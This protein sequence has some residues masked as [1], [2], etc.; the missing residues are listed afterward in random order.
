MIQARQLG[1]VFHPP[2]SLGDLLRG[3][4][5]G[6]AVTALCDVS[7]D[8]AAGEVVCL[9]GENGAGKTTLLRLLAGLLVPSTGRALV[10]GEDLGARGASG[11][12]RRKVALV[13]ADER[14]FMWA[15]SGR[16]N[17]AFFGALHGLPAR[18]AA[19]RADE[20]LERVGLAGA[21]RRRF[22]E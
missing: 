21:V 18:A 13:V 2:G 7:L 15:L 8:V 11:A 19:V 6:P 1:K 4:L 9:M 3:R 12:Y 22:A 20:L 14:S 17:L 5:H 10:A 16:Q